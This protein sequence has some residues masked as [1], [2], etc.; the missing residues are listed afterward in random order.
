MNFEL[1][2]KGIKEALEMGVNRIQLN[3]FGESTMH[4]QLPEFVRYAKDMG[5]ADVFLTSNATLLDEDLS[6]QL[7]ESSLDRIAFSFEGA[8]KETYES[9]REGAT[10]EETKRNIERFLEIRSELESVKPIVRLNTVLMEETKDEIEDVKRMWGKVVDKINVQNFIKKP[11]LPELGIEE[12]NREKRRIC[13]EPA[14]MLSVFW[15]GKVTV[16]CSDSYGELTVG[17]LKESGLKEIWNGREIQKLRERFLKKDYGGLV[18]ED[19][20]DTF[21]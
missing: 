21:R 3:R 2:K 8:T 1:F 20:E 14:L 17:D 6:K 11:G 19:C 5:V 16:C 7:I 18:C 9:I 4:P 15:D 12:N 10:F 13:P